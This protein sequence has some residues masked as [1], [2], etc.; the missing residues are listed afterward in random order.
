MNIK[1]TYLYR[2]AANYKSW[3]EEIFSNVSDIPL[4]TIKSIIHDSLQDGEYFDA[5]SWGLRDLH[6]ENWDEEIDHNFHELGNI[7]ETST[8]K[9]KTDI[10]VFLSQISCKQIT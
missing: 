7:E 10:E 8:P 5:K 9:T 4:E 3:N 1:F 2:D 6:F